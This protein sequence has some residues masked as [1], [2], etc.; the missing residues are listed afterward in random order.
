MRLRT[1][2]TFK[3]TQGFDPLGESSNLELK[4]LVDLTRL[5]ESSNPELK[6]LDALTHL[7]EINNLNTSPQA[8]SQGN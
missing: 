6:K 3:E 5:D 1:L 8:V 4:K 2:E 7:A